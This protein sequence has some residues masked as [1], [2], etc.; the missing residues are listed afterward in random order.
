VKDL[1]RQPAVIE[2][3]QQKSHALSVEIKDLQKTKD[4]HE[5]EVHSDN[6]ARGL[7]HQQKQD[8]TD[9]VTIRWNLKEKNSTWKWR[10][11]NEMANKA[12]ITARPFAEKSGGTDV[13]DDR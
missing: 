11:S 13:F 1:M 10:G 2:R 7:T 5:F 8:E 6:Y 12:T 9:V 3:R 4:L